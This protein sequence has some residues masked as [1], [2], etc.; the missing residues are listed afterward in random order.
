MQREEYL[1]YIKRGDTYK[2]VNY[3]I[4]PILPGSSKGHEKITHSSLTHLC[5][6]QFYEGSQFGFWKQYSTKVAQGKRND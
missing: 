4:I 6:I 2:L 5:E 1:C 3:I